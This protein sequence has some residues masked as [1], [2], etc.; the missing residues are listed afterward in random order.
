M[1]AQAILAQV[2]KLHL[3]IIRRSACRQLVVGR[4]IRM[5]YGDGPCSV[6][7]VVGCFGAPEHVLSFNKNRG[8]ILW[9]KRT[10][11]KTRIGTQRPWILCP[12]GLRRIT[13]KSTRMTCPP[14]RDSTAGSSARSFWPPSRTP[15]S[16]T[17]CRVVTFAKRLSLPI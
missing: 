4:R 3:I 15:P 11:F 14:P 9:K 12:E 2:N 5:E 6:D 8:Y 16:T 13:L 10:R 1:L 17:A 7:V